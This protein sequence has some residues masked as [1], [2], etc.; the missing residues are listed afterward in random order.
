MIALRMAKQRVIDS[1]LQGICILKGRTASVAALLLVTALA[2]LPAAVGLEA[3]PLSQRQHEKLHPLTAPRCSLHMSATG[4]STRDLK[5]HSSPTLATGKPC[6]RAL[7]DQEPRAPVPHAPA[8]PGPVPCAAVLD[9][10]PRCLVPPDSHLAHT[11]VPC[12]PV[13]V[14]YSAELHTLML[15]GRAHPTPPHCTFQCPALL[16]SRP[17]IMP[18]TPASVPRPALLHLHPAHPHPAPHSR[19]RGSPDK[20]LN[21]LT[22]LL[23]ALLTHILASRS[24]SAGPQQRKRRHRLLRYRR[25]RRLASPTYKTHSMHALSFAFAHYSSACAPTTVK[26]QTQQASGGSHAT[27]RQRVGGGGRATRSS[28]NKSHSKDTNPNPEASGSRGKRQ[29]EDGGEESGRNKH[30]KNTD[31]AEPAPP[32]SLPLHALTLNINGLDVDKWEDITRMPVY[33]LLD[34]I[35]LTEHH[36]SSGYRPEEIILDGWE[37]HMVSGPPM[38]G[39]L[40][41]I[42]RGGIA[43]LWRKALNWKVKQD[44][45]CEYKT[46]QSAH[47]CAT[48][49]IT[50]KRFLHPLHITGV[51]VSPRGKDTEGFFQTIEQ[52]CKFP[53][54]H[55]HIFTGDFNAHVAGE[56]EGVLSTVQPG[57]VPLRVGDVA[58][59]RVRKKD[60][61]L[62]PPSP[63]TMG[64]ITGRASS[65]QR[66]RLLLR[67]LSNTGHLLLNGRFETADT[68]SI[69][70]TF[71]RIGRKP[72]ATIND[73]C[74][75]SLHHLQRVKSCKV[76]RRQNHN[77]ATDHNPIHIHLLIPRASGQAG[78]PEVED[79][80][81]QHASRLQFHSSRL[82]NP[83]TKEQFKK[84]VEILSQKKKQ[85]MDVLKANL[86][87][88]TISA[89]AFAE[90]ANQI[91]VTILQAAGDEVLGRASF[92]TS[93]SKREKE[94]DHTAADKGEAAIQQRIQSSRDQLRKARKQGKTQQEIAALANQLQQEKRALDERHTQKRNQTFLQATGAAQT[95]AQD[96]KTP[97]RSMW[98]TSN[99]TKP[100]TRKRT[101]Q[102]RQTTT[103]PQTP[104]YGS[105]D[106]SHMTL[107]SGTDSD[108]PLATTSSATKNP[109]T[110][111]PK[112]D[113]QKKAVLT[114]NTA[115]EIL[116]PRHT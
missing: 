41:H 36:L 62:H 105:W 109:H 65:S 66:G 44:I 52:Q 14:P 115:S 6:A 69:P 79:T 25:A 76:I 102:R 72:E 35:I 75:I 21:P 89:A 80:K 51:Y 9:H 90:E 113:T 17:M 49:T 7:Y 10:T 112:R 110:M 33:P 24:A 55:T 38:K 16:H 77:L 54:Q 12:A 106:H 8:P 34:V 13:L 81:D 83:E 93:R 45:A 99:A 46:H 53:P 57:T 114:R 18:S 70:Y 61:L 5:L 91:I 50:S 85:D 73:Y 92:A 28:I 98:T 43:I 59:K 101:S 56:L 87:N 86:I 19:S 1:D 84:R 100:T 82:K 15:H 22:A 37:I 116:R 40:K 32:A 42:D 95:Q 68:P 104:V 103:D 63:P 111:R 26:P 48:W 67:F 11:S 39:H 74:T 4:R 31:T 2:Y 23:L 29:A 27:G 108:T 20:T 97:N 107:W 94:G 30:P 64:I 71:Q 96:Q 78:E 88:K 58:T 60:Q 3:I 47:Q